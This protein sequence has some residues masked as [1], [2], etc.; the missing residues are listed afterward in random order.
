MPMKIGTK[1]VCTNCQSEFIITKL[2]P[3]AE[4]KCCGQS[5]KEKSA[6]I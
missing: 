1:I 6:L 2:A 4:L 3:Q 5:I